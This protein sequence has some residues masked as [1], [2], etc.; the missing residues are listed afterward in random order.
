[1]SLKLKKIGLYLLFFIIFFAIIYLFIP[2]YAFATLGALI[3]LL[4]IK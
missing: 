4:I 2:S 1:M 3:G